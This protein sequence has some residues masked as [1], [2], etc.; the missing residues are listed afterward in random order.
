MSP[1]KACSSFI[2]P[3]VPAQFVAVVVVMAG[4][5]WSFSPLFFLPPCSFMCHTI[6]TVPNYLDNPFAHRREVTRAN[7]LWYRTLTFAT[8]L[9]NI[10]PTFYY[11]YHIPRDPGYQ[12]LHHRHTIFGQSNAHP[13]PFTINH[14]F[15]GIYWI[16]MFIGQL[17]YIWHLFIDHETWVRAA[18]SVGPH[19]IL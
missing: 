11:T 18:C 10:V 19:F 6:V 4:K 15:V 2:S 14:V 17:G 12:H 9:L 3:Y 7:I 1:C 13:T 8:W 16:A 5:G